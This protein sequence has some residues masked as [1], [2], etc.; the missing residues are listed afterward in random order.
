MMI[1]LVAL[2]VVGIILVQSRGHTDH[3]EW[4]RDYAK[5]LKRDADVEFLVVMQSQSTSL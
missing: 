4:G 2:I 3:D 1:R 5:E